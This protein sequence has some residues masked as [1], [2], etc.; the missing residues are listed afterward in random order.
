MTELEIRRLADMYDIKLDSKLI[1]FAIQCYGKG[2][3]DGKRQ[4]EQVDEMSD[5]D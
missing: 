4:A 2:Y 1:N 5:D 3:S